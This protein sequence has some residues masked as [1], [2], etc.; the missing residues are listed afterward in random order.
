[1]CQNLDSPAQYYW[2]MVETLGVAGGLRSVGGMLLKGIVLLSPSFPQAP[3]MMQGM[4]CFAVSQQDVLPN[5]R[6]QSNKIK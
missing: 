2:E 1:M 6:T 3:A 4:F 5:H